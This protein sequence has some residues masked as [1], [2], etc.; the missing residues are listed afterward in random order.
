MADH[1]PIR[2]VQGHSGPDRGGLSSSGRNHLRLLAIAAA[3]VVLAHLLDPLAFRY[4]RWTDVYSEDWARMLRV[5]GFFPMWLLAGI[6]L[7]LHERTPWRRA[8]RSRAG[9]LV[10]GAGLSGLAAEILKLTFRRLRPGELGEYDF[11]HFLDDPFSTAGFGLP[12]SHA[13]VAFGA[14]AIL[15]RLFP[16]ARAIWWG[17]GW[18]CG[19]TRIGA[20]A[21]FLSDVVVAAI[22][23]WVLGA[24]V[25]RWHERAPVAPPTQAPAREPGLTH[26]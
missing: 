26:V 3:A 21:H 23:A 25:W 18:G 10:F 14:A 17:L 16:R 13:A 20:G 24:V 1:A 19:I 4:I 22:L 15:S 12:S 5:M 8:L 2:P 11:R 6:A 9:L 7:G